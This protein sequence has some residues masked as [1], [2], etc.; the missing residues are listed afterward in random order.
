MTVEGLSN[1]AQNYIKAIWNAGEWSDEP[2]TASVIATRAGVRTSTVSD[3]VRKLA[4]Q[5]LV[6]FE[7]YGEV[8][9]TSQGRELA[10]AMVR[11]HR[12]IETFLVTSLGYGWDEVHD[13]AEELEHA[14]SDK[15]IDRIDEFLGHPTRD[16]HG[17]PIP[18]ADGQIDLPPAIQLA[19]VSPP[20]A[21]TVARIWDGDPQ[22]LAFFAD[23]GIVIDA[24]L[25]ISPGSPF[26][27]T[28][29]VDT[30]AAAVSLST[31]SASAI[32]VVPTHQ[33][34]H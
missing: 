12:L 32:W 18:T 31:E 23:S 9:L 25:T 33:A 30:E 2:I 17:D 19:L 1:S 28:I 20:A 29:Q 13:E 5:D 26:S 7:R 6:N 14:V 10:L 3:A 21:V 15:L 27:G 4:E 24:E 8:T 16:P 11:R 22:Q 34:A